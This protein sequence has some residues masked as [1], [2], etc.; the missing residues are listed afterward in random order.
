MALSYEK[1]DQRSAWGDAL[2]RRTAP[3]VLEE[4]YLGDRTLMRE[5]MSDLIPPDD[6]EGIAALPDMI[7]VTEAL[8]LKVAV[9]PAARR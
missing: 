5:A 8:G 2:L 1:Y 4:R 6:V 9:F 7:A 3:R